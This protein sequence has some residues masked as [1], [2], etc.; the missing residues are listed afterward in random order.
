MSTGPDVLFQ[1]THNAEI[2][3]LNR[4]KALNALNTSMVDKLLSQ[5]RKMENKR[6]L[7]IIK[8]DGTSKAFCAGADIKV[9][10]DTV[11]CYSFV[12]KL[13]NICYLLGNYK[14]PCV[15]L[16]N[17]IAMGGG[18]CMSVHGRYSVATENSI[19]AM[20][21]TKIGYFP[22]SGGSYFLPR[23][24]LNLGFYM[25]LTGATLKGKD[26]V[27][28]GIATHFVPSKRL[29]ELEELLT[30]CTN[31]LE[32]QNLLNKFN[33]PIDEY[34]FAPNIKY[35]SDC[36]AASTVEEIIERLKKVQNESSIKTLETLHLMSPTAL[37]V[38]LNTLQRGAQLDLP[39]CL[40]MEYRVACRSFISHDA[41]EGV[42]ALLV[43]KDNKPQWE[44][45]TLA[46]VDNDTVESYFKTLPQ[47]KELKFFDEFLDAKL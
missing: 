26:A 42:R 13:Y 29:H 21:E 31:D 4:S 18:L 34:S 43:D 44:P 12:S 33:E 38:T 16:L 35:I 19:V 36:F 10:F 5:L 40:K 11:E 15:S 3:T 45:K 14:I 46:E 30:R 25:G 47:E 37:K 32:V 27:K 1:T 2:I 23:L 24:P 20:P 7:V 9:V 39:E 28:A 8:G 17:G 22:D 6:S 41:S